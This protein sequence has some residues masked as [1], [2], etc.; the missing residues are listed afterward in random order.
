MKKYFFCVVSV[1]LITGFASQALAQFTPEELAEREKWEK[2]L[3]TAEI[4]GQTQLGGDEAVT[5][6]WVLDLEQ[7]GIKFRAIWKNP[8]GRVKGFLESWKWEIAAYRLDKL[9]GF[10]VVPPTVE[11]RFRNDLGS[12]QLWIE[13]TFT[14]KHKE[15]NDIKT[16]SY[17]IFPWNRALYIQRAWD[18]LL[19]NEDRHQNQ[20]LITQD[21]RMLLIDHSRSFGTSKKQTTR[22]IYDEKFKEGPRLMKQLPR[23]LYEKIKALTADQIKGAVGDYLTDQEIEGVLMRRDLVVAWVEN[24]IKEMGEDQVLY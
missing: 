5:E 3:E 4:V 1:I 7:D 24:Y 9:L 6:P 8:L 12:C 14:L 11:K 19:D 20:F 16:P 21:W 23:E 17:K 15:E 10:N 18:N 2:L 13:D 22:L